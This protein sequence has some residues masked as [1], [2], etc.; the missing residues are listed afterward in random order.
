MTSNSTTLSINII[1]HLLRSSGR[2]PVEV[3]SPEGQPMLGIVVQRGGEETPILIQL[4]RS[5]N[6]LSMHTVIARLPLDRFTGQHVM[7][8]VPEMNSVN[9]T[10]RAGIGMQSGDLVLI[11]DTYL[12]NMVPTAAW[13]GRQ[14][15]E[16]AIYAG[17]AREVVRQSERNPSHVSDEG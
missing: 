17:Y 1:E 16:L 7:H 2:E 8:H 15:D 10:V 9:R 11:F 4:G 14:L 3:L 13:L 12:M 5:D 6:Y